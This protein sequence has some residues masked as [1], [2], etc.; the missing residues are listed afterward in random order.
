MWAL[1]RTRHSLLLP[2]LPLQ[3]DEGE[4]LAKPPTIA[5][6]FEDHD[7]TKLLEYLSYHAQRNHEE[8]VAAALVAIQDAAKDHDL[9]DSAFEPAGF[10]VPTKVD[11]SGSIHINK[12]NIIDVDDNVEVQITSYTCPCV[13]ACA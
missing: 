5:I 8:N 13:L 7:L 2:T 1:E 4:T 9:P 12:P 6:D 10:W 11:N 3:L